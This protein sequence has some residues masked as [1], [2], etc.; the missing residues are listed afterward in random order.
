VLRP[1]FAVEEGGGRQPRRRLAGRSARV[2]VTMGMPAL[3][4]RIYFRAAGVRGLERS[5]LAFCGIRPVR[6]SLIGL[7]ESDAKGRRRWL[8]RVRRF[9]QSAT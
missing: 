6:E 8:D 9:G 2:I 5:I 1:G 7:V 3:W 4:Y